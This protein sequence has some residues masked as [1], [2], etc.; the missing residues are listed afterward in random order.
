[1][2]VLLIIIG[3]Y[4]INIRNF[5]SNIFEPLKS[6]ITNKGSLYVIIVAFIW[7]ITA[8]LFKFGILASNPIFF[9]ASVYL[10]ISLVMAPILLFK[11]K[12]NLAEIKSNFG[13]LALLGIS[14]AIMI[15]TSSIPMLYSIVPYVISLKRTSVIFSVILGYYLF[16]ERNIRSSLAGASIMLA[17]AVLITLF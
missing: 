3:A 16:N 5:G 12:P 13:L 10:L 9:S 15:I 2:G 6:L 7:S 1:M 11:L 8:N 17:G 14:S 4:I